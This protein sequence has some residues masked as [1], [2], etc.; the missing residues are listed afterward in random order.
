MILSM[1]SRACLS[2]VRLR[3]CL[4]SA[5]RRCSSCAV[6]VSVIAACLL[7][8]HHPDK[9]G[10]TDGA[11]DCAH[12]RR[13]FLRIVQNRFSGRCRPLYLR[14]ASIASF[15]PLHHRKPTRESLNERLSDTHVLKRRNVPM[16][17]SRERLR[18]SPACSW[19]VLFL[20]R[21]RCC[22]RLPGLTVDGARA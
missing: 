1:A 4:Y 19:L 12:T 11:R 5:I 15:H 8:R 9:P 20:F 18:R 22:R 14:R 10:N 2:C 17:C 21:K 13:P 16:S 3:S 6:L 7:A